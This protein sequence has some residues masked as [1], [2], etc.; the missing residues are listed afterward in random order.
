MGA[1]AA[2][3]L[4]PEQ[5]Q[6]SQLPGTLL[7]QPRAILSGLARPCCRL[8]RCEFPGPGDWPLSAQLGLGR[9]ESLP[10]LISDVLS[11]R[12]DLPLPPL[13]LEVRP[14]LEVEELTK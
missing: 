12:Q 14:A 3:L 2:H 9:R 10:P 7:T 5:T 13:F 6:E 1:P 11:A 8:P 4:P